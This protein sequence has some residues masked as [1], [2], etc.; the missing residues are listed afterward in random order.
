MCFRQTWIN[1]GIENTEHILRDR[2]SGGFT[3][4]VYL[5]Y[6]IRCSIVACTYPGTH[7]SSQI[8]Q[9]GLTAVQTTAIP[10]VY[11]RDGAFPWRPPLLHLLP[12]VSDRVEGP[13]QW[14]IRTTSRLFRFI[15]ALPSVLIFLCDG[16]PFYLPASIPYEILLCACLW[17][18]HCVCQ[19]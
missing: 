7:G 14:V 1:L 3:A 8:S 16:V 10:S 12:L 17:S 4:D 13:F 5:T 18:V 19:I 9:G 6:T 11:R 2:I 15:M